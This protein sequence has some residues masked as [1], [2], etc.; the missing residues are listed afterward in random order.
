MVLTTF[1]LFNIEQNL[2]RFM[3]NLIMYESIKILIG[4]FNQ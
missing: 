1:S 3:Q 2:A 4:R